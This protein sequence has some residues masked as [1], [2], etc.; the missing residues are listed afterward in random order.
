MSNVLDELLRGLGN[1]VTDIC[2]KVVEEPYFGRVVTE[3]TTHI[4]VATED[5]ALPE[6]PR[7]TGAIIQP[8]NAPDLASERGGGAAEVEPGKD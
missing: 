5:A 4:D 3:G 7:A 8:K 6:F 2:H 1:A